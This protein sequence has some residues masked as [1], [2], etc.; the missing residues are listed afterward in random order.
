M[1]CQI[2]KKV[3]R[4]SKLIKTKYITIFF[5]IIGKQCFVLCNLQQYFIGLSSEYILGNPKS[6][7]PA[8]R[9]LGPLSLLILCSPCMYTFPHNTYYWTSPYPVMVQQFFDL[10]FFVIY[11]GT[12]NGL[13]MAVS[14]VFHW[15]AFLKNL[16]GPWQK[17]TLLM[18]GLLLSVENFFR[19][20]CIF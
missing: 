9:H 20:N 3:V 8:H 6:L 5:Q 7:S 16:F 10:A 18:R 2:H 11:L 19:N 1:N 17:N 15:M 4:A 12:Q 13:C 14:C